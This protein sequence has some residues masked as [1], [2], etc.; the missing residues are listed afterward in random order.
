MRLRACRGRK[1][2]EPGIEA[3]GAEHG[4]EDGGF[5]RPGTQKSAHCP[6]L[7]SA[8]FL[9]SVTSP[10]GEAGQAAELGLGSNPSSDSAG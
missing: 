7:P 6:S 3:G 8:S 5:L 4:G 10:S 9:P 2:A 1:E